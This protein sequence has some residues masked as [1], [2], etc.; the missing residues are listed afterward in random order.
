M[1]ILTK[2]GT[3][4][5]AVACVVTNKA[6]CN[7]LGVSSTRAKA[8]ALFLTPVPVVRCARAC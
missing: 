3:R 4:T 8:F 2:G 6:L 1:M 5:V 7:N